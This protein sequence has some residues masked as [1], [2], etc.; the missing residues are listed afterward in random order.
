MI[1]E[2]EIARYRCVED[3]GSPLT[4]LEFQRFAIVQTRAGIRRIPGAR[5]LALGSGEVIQY[6]DARTF[7]V[8]ITGELLR[9]I[10]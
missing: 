5:R 3:D 2:A 7:E 6:I 9:L 4:V 8:V 10:D 1:E